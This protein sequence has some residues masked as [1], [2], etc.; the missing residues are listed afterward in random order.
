VWVA[1]QGLRLVCIYLNFCFKNGDIELA[2]GT[3]GGAGGSTVTPTTTSELLTYLSDS[4]T[5]PISLHLYDSSVALI[6]R[7]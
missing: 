2:L 7:L 6:Y 5:V 3:T 4:T 1:P